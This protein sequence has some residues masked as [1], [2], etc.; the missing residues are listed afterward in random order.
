MLKIKLR[1]VLTPLN[2]FI[3][4]VLLSA[5]FLRVYRLND[6]LGF[7]YDQGRD[8]LVIWDLLYK[9]KFFLIGPTTGIA[10]IFR[11]PFY[12]YLIAPFY[13]IGRGDPAY[14]A[15]FLAALSVGAIWILYRVALKLLDKPTAILVTLLSSFSF[16]IVMAGRWLS[17]PTPMLVLS[18]LLIWMMV[19]VTKG[20]KPAWIAI[21]FIVGASIFHFGSAAE[22]F[23]VPAVIVFALW[24]RKNLPDLKIMLLSVAAFLITVAPIVLFDLRHDGILRKNISGFVTQEESF[25]IPSKRNVKDKIELYYDVFTNKIFHNRGRN[26]QAILVFMAVSFLVFLPSIIKKEIVRILLILFLSGTV[27]LT[28]FKGNYGVVYDYY[29]TGYYLIFMFLFAIVLGQLWKF[30]F[31]KVFVIFFLYLFLTSNLN[32][33]WY[34]INDKGDNENS[35]AYLN[36]KK[37]I[38]WVYQDATRDSFNVDVYVPPVIPYAYDYLFVWYGERVH[39]R[40]PVKENVPLLYTLYEVDPPHPE[41]L[42]AW[43][44]RQMGIGEIEASARF[45]GITVERRRRI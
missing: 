24:Q 18:A 45:G 13:L 36:Q 22:I 19:Q 32:V 29:L 23:F 31:G 39:G 16:Y 41:R 4:A 14:P 43:L 7:Y 35:V 2:L 1:K 26:E 6:I 15:I 25:G 21:S 12:Y 27:G 34:K 33:T 20:K 42:G 8:A 17:N 3:G 9:G 10:G 38:D 11:G 40:E 30:S 28:F 44:T 37:A 5:F